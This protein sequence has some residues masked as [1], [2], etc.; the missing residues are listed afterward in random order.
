VN[1]Y[2]SGGHLKPSDNQTIHCQEDRL[3]SKQTKG[4]NEE[5]C[6]LVWDATQ[7]QNNA[8]TSA[9]NKGANH[10]DS[11][12]LQ[13]QT[14]FLSQFNSAKCFRIRAGSPDTSLQMSQPRHQA[15]SGAQL[16]HKAHSTMLRDLTMPGERKAEL[17]G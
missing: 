15:G 1:T 4:E 16:P 14:W 3:M 2:R 5:K 8:L 12:A 9:I 7:L 10:P 6:R 13:L 17:Q 11:G